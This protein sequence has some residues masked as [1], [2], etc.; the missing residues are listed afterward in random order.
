MA[1]QD[2][3]DRTRH[4]H[5]PTDA[6]HSPVREVTNTETPPGQIG[7]DGE[8]A[9]LVPHSLALDQFFEQHHLHGWVRGGAERVAED[10]YRAWGCCACGAAWNDERSGSVAMPWQPWGATLE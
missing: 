2:H 3:A 10:R 4:G 1:T 7:A 6:R 9:V 8:E 5:E